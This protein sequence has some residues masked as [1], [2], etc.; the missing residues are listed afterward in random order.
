MQGVK[1]YSIGDELNTAL[2]SSPEQCLPYASVSGFVK[3]DILPIQVSAGERTADGVIH[4]M[5]VTEHRSEWNKNSSNWYV[6]Y[7]CL[8]SIMV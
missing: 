3:A 4:K 5:T 8:L 7:V 6:F 1:L 2:K